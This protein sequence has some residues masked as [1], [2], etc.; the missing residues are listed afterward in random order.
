M[1]TAV[2]WGLAVATFLTTLYVP[3]LYLMTYRIS[4]ATGRTSGW[5]SGRAT[6]SSRLGIVDSSRCWVLCCCPGGASRMY[7]V[8]G[9]NVPSV[10]WIGSYAQTTLDRYH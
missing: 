10:M 9:Q 3:T 4:Q 6:R 8:T 7:Q 5:F 2:S 1:A